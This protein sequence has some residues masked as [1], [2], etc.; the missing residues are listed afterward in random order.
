LAQGVLVLQLETLL[1][2][3]DQIPFLVPL[4]LQAVDMAV[5]HP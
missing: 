2:Q 3:M 1:P 5:L 4:H